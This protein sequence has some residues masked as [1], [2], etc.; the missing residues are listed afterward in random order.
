M[1]AKPNL[2]IV[3]ELYLNSN[4][5]LIY[6]R[7]VVYVYELVSG[8]LEL[9]KTTGVFKTRCQRSVTTEGCKI[10]RVIS[11]FMLNVDAPPSLTVN[12]FEA[13]LYKILSKTLNL[14]LNVISKSKPL[15]FK[16]SFSDFVNS[17]LSLSNLKFFTVSTNE[18]LKTLNEDLKSTK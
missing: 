17:V 12:V 5:D 11:L 2:N 18:Q 16:C 7:N 6:R 1:F 8:N 9:G 13:E 15:G 10:V 4:L 3:T 14:S